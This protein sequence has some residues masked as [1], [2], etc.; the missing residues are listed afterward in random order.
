MT[1]LT[2]QLQKSQA[3]KLFPE[4]VL[5]VRDVKTLKLDGCV[6]EPNEYL[7][8]VLSSGDQSLLSPKTCISEN[9]QM[10][11]CFKLTLPVDF[12]ER[13]K[14]GQRDQPALKETYLHDENLL[15]KYLTEVDVKRV[16][17]GSACTVR[18]KVYT[19][20]N[21]YIVRIFI[22]HFFPAELPSE[23][24]ITTIYFITM[25]LYKVILFISSVN[26]TSK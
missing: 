24:F 10:R 3:K 5:L 7:S 26:L 25:K 13:D 17:T 16:V 1:Q 15:I 18:G 23:K 20:M 22:T 6:V 12:E 14:L 11:S 2:K 21:I 8:R 9:C 19:Q 4:F